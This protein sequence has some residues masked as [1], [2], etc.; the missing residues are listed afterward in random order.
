M[1]VN[2]PI[3]RAEGYAGFFL[4]VLL[5]AV[6]AAV[7]WGAMQARLDADSARLNTL[8]THDRSTNDTLIEVRQDVKWIREKLAT[9]ASPR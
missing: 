9:Q 7:A 6:A 2:E 4:T 8:E 3:R 1:G 5:S